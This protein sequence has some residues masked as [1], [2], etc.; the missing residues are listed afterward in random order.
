MLCWYIYAFN[1]ER[2]ANVRWANVR[3][4]NARWANVR[5]AKVRW[6]KVLRPRGTHLTA[7]HLVGMTPAG[8]TCLCILYRYQ[9]SALHLAP[10]VTSTEHLLRTTW[11]LPTA[12]ACPLAG[13]YCFRHSPVRFS[14]AG[15]RALEQQ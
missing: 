8:G 13:G 12:P 3:W 9:I 6:A 14:F 11:R 4:A 15:A 2:W 1:Q 10:A 7:L 5:W